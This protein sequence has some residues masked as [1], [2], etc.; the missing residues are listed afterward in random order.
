MQERYYIKPTGYDW[1]SQV[2]QCQAA[3]NGGIIR[4]QVV[5]VEREVGVHAFVTEVSRRRFRLVRTHHHFVVI[6]NDGPIEVV[7]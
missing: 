2:F 4:R 6:C 3:R 1:L 5:D 7:L